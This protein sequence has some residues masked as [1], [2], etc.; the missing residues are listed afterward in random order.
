M[1]GA[2]STAVYSEGS[3]YSSSMAYI[4]VSPIAEDEESAGQFPPFTPEQLRWI[5]RLITAKTELDNSRVENTVEDTS[6][7]VSD[8]LPISLVAPAVG[9]LT[10][11]NTL[12]TPASWRGSH[13]SNSACCE[14]GIVQNY[15]SSWVMAQWP[16]WQP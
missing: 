10:P 14:H 5:D 7:P 6:T 1:G 15:N 8:P 3:K 12:A 9:S 11:T 13:A 2:G 4:V 16:G